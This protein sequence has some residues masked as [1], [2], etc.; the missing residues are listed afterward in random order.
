MTPKV[1]DRI[2][3]P[4]GDIRRRPGAHR[5]IDPSGYSKAA[6]DS[7]DATFHVGTLQMNAFHRFPPES[8][9]DFTFGC[10]TLPTGNAI[11]STATIEL[12]DE[13]AGTCHSLVHSEVLVH[14]GLSKTGTTWLQDHL[15]G[16]EAVFYG[17]AQHETN[18]KQ[19]SK[20]YGRLLYLCQSKRLIDEDSFDASLIRQK[21][22]HVVVPEGAVPVISNERLSSHVLSGAHDR[23]MLAQR[24][25][26]VF[27][28]TP[29]F[30]VC[31]REQ[32]SMILSSYMQYLRYGGWHSL[33]K[34]LSPP[35]DGRQRRAGLEPVPHRKYRDTNGLSGSASRRLQRRDETD[36]R[37]WTI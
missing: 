21:L 4:F 9:I 7:L 35:S 23:K 24:I 1:G 20:E 31:I 3:G 19:R 27:P 30:F 5:V 26:E 29:F 15:F 28:R 16:N 17:A 10:A 13:P 32:H 12:R 34:F 18:L 14:V 25:K 22:A 37:H 33:K 2:A 6:L 36:R 11:P 8:E